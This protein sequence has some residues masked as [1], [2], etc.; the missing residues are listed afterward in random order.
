M[1]NFSKFFAQVCL[2][3]LIILWVYAAISKLA[4]FSQFKREMNNQRLWPAVKVFLTYCL[5]PIEIAT[6]LMLTFSRSLLKGLYTSLVLLI[7]FTGYIALALAH[8]FKHVPCP[9]GGLLT[10][11]TWNTHAIFNLILI[12]LTIYPIFIIKRKE[13]SV[14]P[15]KN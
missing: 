5:P 9:C 12:I 10:N 8:F 14:T 11:M 7:L 13:P 4:D 3:L 6:A 15:K 2:F 1:N